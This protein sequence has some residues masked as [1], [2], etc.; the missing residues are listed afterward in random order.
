MFTSAFSCP[1]APEDYTMHVMIDTNPLYVSKAGIARYLRSLLREFEAI[2]EA[3]SLLVEQLAWPVENF[4]YRQPMRAARTFY[5]EMVWPQLVASPRITKRRPD[6][7]HR[8]SVALELPVPAGTAEVVTLHDLAVIR[9]PERFRRWH[10]ARETRLLK[11]IDEAAHL[12][13]VS[14][15]TAQEARELLGLPASRMTV[16][17]HAN[18]FTPG[19]SRASEIPAG[20]PWQKPYFLFVGSLEPGK[21]LRLLQKAYAIAGDRWQQPLPMVVVGARREGVEAEGPAP[22]RWH[23][24]GHISDAALQA[25]YEHAH[26][27]VFPSKYEGFG[28]PVLEAMGLGCPVICS[29]VASLPEVGGDAVHYVDMDPVAYLDAM[30]ELAEN[31]PL[32]ESL[33]AK[34]R[35][36]ASIFSWSRAARE[37][38]AVYRKAASLN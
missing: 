8:T 25:L 15:F 16:V 2:S 26:A 20:I 7:L 13:C 12:V 30:L 34:G 6:V 33:I 22:E 29:A 37:T 4:A 19:E 1:G 23:Y 18:Q 21:N 10:R 3:E 38:L 36:R 5:R 32:R 14:D 11:R 28:I 9:Y 24:T 27:L 31:T 35:T 17:H